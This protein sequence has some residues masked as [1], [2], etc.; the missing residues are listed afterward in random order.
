MKL[1]YFLLIYSFF[2]LACKMQEA[3]STQTSTTS[4]APSSSCSVGRWPNLGTGLN[5]KI[6]SEFAGDYTNADLINNLNPI[7]QVA[8][9]WNDSISGK[10]FFALPM[11]SASSSGY[12]DLNSFRDGEMGIYKSH[13][14]YNDVS[15]G[16]LAITQ[17]FG[18]A[19]SSQSLGS[20]IELTHADIIFNYRDFGSIFSFHGSSSSNYD[21]PTV[22]LHEMGHFLGL[23]HDSG[24][25]SA[26]RPYYISKQRSLYTFDITKITDL[27]VNNKNTLANGNSQALGLPDG[28]E[29]SGRIELLA[30]G[31]C[32]HFINGKLIFEHQKEKSPPRFFEPWKAFSYNLNKELF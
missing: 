8:K 18:R 9:T 21:V 30:N 19:Q 25:I 27:Y 29:V 26:M 31:T 22:L 10:T 16:A 5:V 24:H 3:S 4:F 12:S 15:S 23:C 1:K 32:K 20:Y 28:S 13:T 2:M 6:S 7:E 11:A 17:F 14:W